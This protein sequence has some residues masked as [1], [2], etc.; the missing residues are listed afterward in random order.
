M[1][2][3]IYEVAMGAKK[4]QNYVIEFGRDVWAS[5]RPRPRR[6][7]ELE[8]TE[9]SQPVRSAP[10]PEPEPTPV[11]PP[12]PP[13]PQPYSQGVSLSRLRPSGAAMTPE[14]AR[15]AWQK[16]REHEH[17]VAVTK[18][19]REAKAMVEV[20][21]KCKDLFGDL[22]ILTPTDGIRVE[23]VELHRLVPPHPHAGKDMVALRILRGNQAY[24]VLLYLADAIRPI[25][26][27]PDVQRDHSL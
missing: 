1:P 6:R 9:A 7:A 19:K 4:F 5:L 16:R 2:L 3:P 23:V 24:R 13:S 8:G 18:R 27:D 12:P 26:H 25:V 14:E 22:D 17:K 10:E 21:H 15:T 20:A 11:Q